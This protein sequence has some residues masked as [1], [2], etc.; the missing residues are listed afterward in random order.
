MTPP[1][2][3]ALLCLLPLAA[4][5]FEDRPLIVVGAAGGDGSSGAAGASGSPG[6]GGSAGSGGS[7]VTVS[8]AGGTGAGGQASTFPVAGCDVRPLFVGPSSVYKCSESAICHDASGGGANFRLA[9]TD[10]AHLVGVVPAG[11][12]TVPSICAKDPL[13]KNMPYIIKGSP[14]GD[15]LI[16]RKVSAPAGSAVCSPGGVPMPLTG[17]PVSAADLVCIREWLIALANLP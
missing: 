11:G 1:T 5:C 10:V 6:T 12:G 2:R 8:G 3:L 17:Y 15:G 9:S 13:Y 14:D 16:W 7:P 4:G